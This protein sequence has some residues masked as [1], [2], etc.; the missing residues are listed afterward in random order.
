[1]VAMLSTVATHIS[2]GIWHGLEEAI[3][4]IGEELRVMGGVLMPFP[5]LYAHNNTHN[6]THC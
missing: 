6:N 1:M 5:K 3:L 2:M 4:S